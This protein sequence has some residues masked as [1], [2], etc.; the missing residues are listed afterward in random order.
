MGDVSRSTN[1]RVPRVV[2]VCT[3]RRTCS[4]AGKAR[5]FTPDRQSSEESRRILSRGV[6]RGCRL[7]SNLPRRGVPSVQDFARR[8]GTEENVE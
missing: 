5:I 7:A 2:A 1:V 4:K 3:S 8:L 6:A